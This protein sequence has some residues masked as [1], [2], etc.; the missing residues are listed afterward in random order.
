M[1]A[2]PNSSHLVTT[3]PRRATCHRCRRV[4]LEGVE[5]GAP[6]RVD[7]IPLT[8]AGELA[9]RLEHRNTYRVLAGRIAL[10]EPLDIAADT[11]R[12][13]PPVCATHSCAPI[14]PSHVDPTHAARFAE[15]AADTPKTTPDEERE[16]HTLF[17]LTGAFAGAKVIAITDEDPPF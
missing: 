6:Y 8:L 2:T 7:A 14:N 11:T 9:A 4:V 17:V 5:M 15:L 13:R 16:Q 1:S 10:R 3:T 12:G